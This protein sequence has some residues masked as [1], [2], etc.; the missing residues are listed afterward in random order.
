MLFV[1]LI[2]ESD[3]ELRDAIINSMFNNL[4]YPNQITFYFTHLILLFF[5]N[6][7]NEHIHE[8]IVR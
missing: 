8:Q 5:T 1:K 6:V 2:K 3:F 7:D 4:R